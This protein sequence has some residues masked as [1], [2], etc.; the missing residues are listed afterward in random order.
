MKVKKMRIP[1]KKQFIWSCFAMTLVIVSLSCSKDTYESLSS[2]SALSNK[3][4]SDPLFE[5]LGKADYEM[6]TNAI[7]YGGEKIDQEADAI[8]TEDIKS[9]KIKS[10]E[11]LVKR[12][13][14]LGYKDYELRS[15]ARLEYGMTYLALM[16]KYPELAENKADFYAFFA[17]NN[18]SKIPVETIRKL[19]IENRKS[20]SYVEK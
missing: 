3:L 5:K 12:K 8:L 16:K 11:E 7:K 1:L 9:G 20:R 19:L 2:N 14:A 15:K 4:L 13:E 17:K 10:K 18:T 6:K